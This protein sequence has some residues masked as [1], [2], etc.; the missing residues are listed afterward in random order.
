MYRLSSMQGEKFDE[1][2]CCVCIN[3]ENIEISTKDFL[4][5]GYH[6]SMVSTLFLCSF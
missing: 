5:N 1:V 6:G 4:Q 2:I 3:I